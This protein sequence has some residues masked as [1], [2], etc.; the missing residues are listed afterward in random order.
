MK[1]L[2]CLLFI[3][4]SFTLQAEELPW[5]EINCNLRNADYILKG[6]IF[7]EQGSIAILHDYSQE[8]IQEKE[9]IIEA[10]GSPKNFAIDKFYSSLIGHTI[11]MFL[12]FDSVEQKLK[13]AW[14]GWELSTLWMEGELLKSVIQ[15]ENPGGWEL[16]AFYED[17]TEL[18]IQISNWDVF[19]KTFCSFKNYDNN[20]SRVYY[21]YTI[22]K[23]HPFKVEIIRE[24]KKEKAI[25]A[26]YLK[27]LV[28][29][30]FRQRLPSKAEICECGWIDWEE[31]MY[32]ELFT[33]FKETVGINYQKEFSDFISALKNTIDYMEYKRSEEINERFIIEFLNFM[34]SN[35]VKNWEE[36]KEMLRGIIAKNSVY[37]NDMFEYE[38]LEKLK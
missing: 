25:A 35:P 24:I 9:I 28:W 13:P 15:P 6:K 19:N 37:Y 11:I 36:E 23:W 29:E 21:L 2:I 20:K 34:N 32:L 17:L 12:K 30:L 22:F 33:A 1:K 27:N 4:Q 5:F 26:K 14:W 7:D 18:E 10:F 38:L 16:M 3:V 8:K 31:N